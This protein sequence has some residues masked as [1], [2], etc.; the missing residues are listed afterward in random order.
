[1]K[2]SS[3]PNSQTIFRRADDPSRE[4]IRERCRKIRQEWSAA[5][6]RRRAGQVDQ[7]WTVPEAQ[8]LTPRVTRADNPS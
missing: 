3:A 8:I 2:N 5:T 7:P 1:M 4:E 6:R